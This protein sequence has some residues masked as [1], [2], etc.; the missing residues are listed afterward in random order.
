MPWNNR[1]DGY[2]LLSLNFTIY[3]DITRYAYVRW[4]VVGRWNEA[5]SMPKPSSIRPAVSIQYR[6]VWLTDRRTDGNTTTAYAIKPTGNQSF[7]VPAWGS[8]VAGWTG[9]GRKQR[10][11]CSSNHTPFEW[12]WDPT[13]VKRF[14]GK[15]HMPRKGLKSPPH[16]GLFYFVRFWTGCVVMAR[17]FPWHV[18]NGPSS[19]QEYGTRTD[20]CCRLEERTWFCGLASQ[21]QPSAMFLGFQPCLLWSPNY[22][23]FCF[24]G[25]YVTNG[26]EHRSFHWPEGSVPVSTWSLVR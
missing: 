2:F 11:D 18:W 22:E 26:R 24:L 5:S 3:T 13:L 19:E 10:G 17:H 15:A 1:K 20:G 8:M 21:R 16:S 9:D 14:P 4:Y 25:L 23:H 6:G 7:W 12:S